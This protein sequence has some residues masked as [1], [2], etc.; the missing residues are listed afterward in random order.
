[1]TGATGFLG[2]H[3]AEA[4]V[5]DGHAVRCSVRRSS[6]T[7]W[8]DPL[9]VERVVLDLSDP[10]DLA[11]ALEGTDAVVHCGGLTRARDEAEFQR[12][13][14]A[15]TESLAAA[16]VAAGAARF[17]FVSSLAARGPDG[18]GGPVSAYGRSKAAGERLLEAFRDRLELVVLRP[19]GVYGPRDDDLLPLFRAA[20]RGFLAVPRSPHPL[21]PVYVGDVVSAT[22]AALEAEPSVDP[23]PVA[24]PRR[25]TWDDLA[26]ALAAAVGGE[27]RIVHLPPA[28]FWSV[29]LL[30]ELASRLTGRSP[31]MD[32]RRARDLS[33]L[34]WTC[35][36]DE[37]R[38]ALDWEPT[39]D[40]EL[41]LRVTAAWYREVGWL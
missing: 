26:A 33:R 2:S 15:G 20:A 21:Q 40:I 25:H 22:K 4:L 3:L 31:A 12:V 41:G 9:D 11:T 5:A 23:L 10:G 18:S 16:A 17:V 34:R 19:G 30:S 6:D 37:T 39:V 8:I 35:D 13:N 29:G 14:A 7:R 38:R 32:R 24:H 36:I 27:P 28:F 1:M